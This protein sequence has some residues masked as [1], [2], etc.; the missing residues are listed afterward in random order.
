[1]V[2]GYIGKVLRV[3]L[4]NREVRE[5][6]LEET[7]LKKFVGQ[8]GIG[9]KILYDEVPPG[10]KG[11]DPENR[12]IF[13]TGPFTGTRVQSPSN[14]EVITRSALPLPSCPFAVANS[15]G[16]W[17]PR[18]KAAGY[19]GMIVQGRADRPV[20]LWVHDGECEIRDAGRIWGKLDTFE[21]EDAIKKELGQERASVAA[22][23]PAGENLVAA[24]IVENEHGH[25]AAKGNTGTV[26]GS[27]NLKAIAVYGTGKVPIANR[28]EFR[29]AAKKWREESFT[30]PIG[31]SVNA[32]GTAGGIPAIHEAGQ[33]PT[34]NFTTGV[35]PGYEKITGQYMREKY[36]MKR[37]PCYGCSLAHCHIMTVTEGPYK[38]FVGEEPEYED[39][40]NLGSNIGLGDA[41][42]IAWLTDY[43]DRLG[44]DGNWAGAIVSW[45]MEAVDRGILTKETLDDLE[46]R[47]GDEKAAAELLRRVAYREGIGDILALGLKEGP[48]RIGGKEAASFA[49][50]F[51]GEANHAH[52]SRAAWGQFLGLCISGGGPRWESMGVDRRPDPDIGYQEP[53]GRYK[54]EGKAEEARRTQMIK[55]F[56]DTLGICYFGI[57][58]LDTMVRGYQALTGWPLSNDG[59]LLIGERIA[60]MQR[61]FN[62]R[63]SFKPEM[64]LDVSPRLLEPPPDGGAQG[65]TIAPYLEGMVREYS[66]RMDW[67]WQTGR[68]S[69]KKLDELGLDD[70]AKDLWG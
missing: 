35:F 7:L 29:E 42:A 25:I 33:L 63:H 23:G 46:L 34:K 69:R 70:V 53:T 9:V 32:W 21:T 57:A 64:D 27:K 36:Q 45:A 68:P 48:E 39:M 26:M 54:V 41:G 18:L 8:I 51:K 52:D 37:N 6:K 44:L 55:L 66:Q 16:F 67:D 43:V 22:I 19:D 62:V 13:M 40:S 24:A 38:G 5:E 4:T 15:H 3:D 56:I 61:A 10:V 30:M 65:K 31:S 47:W 50:H 17:G 58:R 11:I 20:Y 59:A 60:N 2:G 12:L 1:M 49:V 14:Y 28:E